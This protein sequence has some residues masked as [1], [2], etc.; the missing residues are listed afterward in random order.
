MVSDR[1][2]DYRIPGDNQV[3][4]SD[5][6]VTEIRDR[7]RQDRENRFQLFLLAAGMRNRYL[8][9]ATNSYEKEFSDWYTKKKMNDLFGGL[10]NFTKYA[11]AGDVVAHVASSS[12]DPQKFL[13]RLPVSVGALYEISQILN[14]GPEVFNLCLRFTATRKTLDQPKHEWTTKY[15][16]LIRHNTTE[17]QVRNWRRHWNNPPPVRQKRT[18]KRTL[19][20]AVITCSGELFDFHRKTG[21]KIGC[22]DL[23]EV[24]A[25]LEKL[26]S[27]FTE[28]NALQFKIVDSMDYLTEGYFKR[29]A[30]NDPARILLRQKEKDEK[31]KQ[32]YK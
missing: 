20:F 3:A 23:P 24:E 5:D 26:N 30:Y 9:K 19:P 28:D 32:R 27:L 10:S 13:D 21:E 15:P 2:V 7:F 8:N 4:L 25:F 16:A 12:S 6:L 11:S 17:A 31:K 29:E 22:L 1:S 18:D 14:D